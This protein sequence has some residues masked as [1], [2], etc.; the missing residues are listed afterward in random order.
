MVNGVFP[1]P[2]S[3]IV[4]VWEARRGSQKLPRNTRSL[5]EATTRGDLL[6]E[7]TG[8][9]NTP[10]SDTAYRV[11]ASCVRTLLPLVFSGNLRRW[12]KVRLSASRICSVGDS[13]AVTG[14]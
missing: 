4:T 8:S 5:T 6:S 13:P 7:P 9:T 1:R 3:L 12:R 14:I 11:L 10:E 2:G